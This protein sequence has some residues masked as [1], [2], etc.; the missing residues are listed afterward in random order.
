VK[1]I[2]ILT[3]SDVKNDSR[4]LRYL[5]SVEKNYDLFLLGNGNF[6]N[7]KV[8]Y[9][10]INYKLNRKNKSIFDFLYYNFYLRFKTYI[11]VKNVRPDIVHAND[12]E[13]FLPSYF[14]FINKKD[15]IIYDSHEIWC[16]RAGVRK[17]ILTRIF[18]YLEY[19]LEKRLIKKIKYFVTVSNSIKNYFEEKYQ[20]KNIFV[21]RNFPYLNSYSEFEKTIF[22]FIKNEKRIKFVYIGP[23]SSERNIPF[24]LEVFKNFEKD[25]HL[26]LIG[27]NLL[28]LSDSQNIKIFD[29]IEE[30]KVIPTLK[31]FDIGVHP[32]KTNNLN[33]KF[34]LPNKIFQY[35][36][37]SLAIFV[38]EN[39]E[40]LKIVE[41]CNNGF[42]ADFSE[43]KNVLEKLERFK[44]VDLKK[45]KENSYK[46]FIEF[47]N[48]ER[49]KIVYL[50]ILKNL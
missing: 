43:R 29:N 41:R 32:L 30:K 18:N 10:D 31:L 1:K 26:T 48:W 2:F 27:K 38:Y 46:N 50:N 37:S 15:S 3:F 45:L 42:T 44:K 33:H 22:D 36:A 49:E 17:N 11:T 47:Y 25:Y 4:I 28:K 9:I 23:I 24:L 14:A 39:V 21:V 35:M 16:E 19:L 34:S 12:F 6:T 40:T 8:H 13:T 20:T 7:K 5:Q